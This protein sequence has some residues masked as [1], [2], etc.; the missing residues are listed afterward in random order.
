L[1]ALPKEWTDAL[2][3]AVQAGKIPDIP[4]STSPDGGNPVY[5]N[6]LDP[7]SPEVCSSTAKCRIDGDIWDA[8]DGYF[9]MYNNS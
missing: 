5:P 4:V 3:A 7:G 2:D 1:N 6:N 9:G 8:P